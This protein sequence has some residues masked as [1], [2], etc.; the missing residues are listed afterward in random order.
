MLT[1]YFLHKVSCQKKNRAKYLKSWYVEESESHFSLL[2]MEGWLTSLNSPKNSATNKKR[3]EKL[4]PPD[5]KETMNIWK[6]ETNTF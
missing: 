4:I 3:D 1:N 5:L 2:S 6:L